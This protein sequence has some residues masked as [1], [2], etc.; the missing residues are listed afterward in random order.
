MVRLLRLLCQVTQLLLQ[1]LY[2]LRL[3]RA[4]GGIALGVA[5]WGAACI[6]CM[7]Q[8]QHG[9]WM[10]SLLGGVALCSLS[11]SCCALRVFW[12]WADTAGWE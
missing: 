7:A 9:H 5:R 4:A 1:Q 11:G 3:A 10:G 6:A 8:R 12:H 2:V